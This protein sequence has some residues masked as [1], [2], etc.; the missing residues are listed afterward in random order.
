ATTILPL[1][2][3]VPSRSTAQDSPFQNARWTV[4]PM[5]LL[6][7]GPDANRSQVQQA[8]DPS[9]SSVQG[10]L[11]AWTRDWAPALPSS[12]VGSALALD[13]QAT[14]CSFLRAQMASSH[15]ARAMASSLG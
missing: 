11:P 10:S 6:R 4:P 9:E 12:T 15:R 13:Q 1:Q 8:T 2:R 3:T 7:A 14:S 5:S